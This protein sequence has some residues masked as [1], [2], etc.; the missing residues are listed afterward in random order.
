MTG[1]EEV[2]NFNAS[3]C[4]AP[5]VGMFT[6]FE[7]IKYPIDQ[8]SIQDLSQNKEEIVIYSCALAVA[9][10]LWVVL[11]VITGR[12]KL[13]FGYAHVFLTVWLLILVPQLI[14][15]VVKYFQASKMNS[16]GL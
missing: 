5:L 13:K 3:M 12:Q 7:R 16:Y 1:E 4:S 11:M 10:I 6:A 2:I 9:I 15:Q 14:L 8:W